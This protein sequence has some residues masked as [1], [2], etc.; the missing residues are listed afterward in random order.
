MTDAEYLEGVKGNMLKFNGM[1]DEFKSLQKS[2]VQVL[3]KEDK[4]KVLKTWY[5]PS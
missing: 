5:E 2:Y 4:V 1:L 3:S